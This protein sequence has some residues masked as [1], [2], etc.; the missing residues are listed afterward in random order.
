LVRVQDGA[1]KKNT[2]FPEENERKA[3]VKRG[4]FHALAE[5]GRLKKSPGISY[6][7]RASG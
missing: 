1:L 4:F 3:P 7:V 5:N 2:V 6:D